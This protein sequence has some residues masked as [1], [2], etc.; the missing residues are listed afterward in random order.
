MVPARRC[1][2]LA[3]VLSATCLH[4]G[5][6]QAQ[7]SA[8]RIR[9]FGLDAQ[10]V[11]GVGVAVHGGM[12]N[13]FLARGRAGLLYAFEP[14]MFNLGPTVEFG[15]LADVGFGGEIELNHFDGLFF[16]VGVNT[17]HEDT[18]MSHVVAGFT[19]F[20]LE[21]QHRYAEHDSDA[22]LL[23]V[24]LPFGMWWLFKHK[25]ET[26]GEAAQG[27]R[28]SNCRHVAQASGRRGSAAARAPTRRCRRHVAG[29]AS[30]GAR[31]PEPATTAP[32]A[33][34]RHL[35]LQIEIDGKPEP[36]A[37][38]GY[39]IHVEPGEHEL[40]VR[41]SSTVLLRQPFTVHPAELVR[42]PVQS[43]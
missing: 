39:D 23:H 12:H 31:G 14:W 13:P 22:L 42:I 15:A 10:L 24:R 43:E 5:A 4:A 18:V 28:H 17:A 40:V 7:D 9:G 37:A 26:E 29:A 11:G 2:L 35:G 38:L 32:G 33:H 1:W 3:L 21:W 34:G 36:S 6:A 19:V 30:A 20:G 25:E 27:S 16:D 8:P 41:N